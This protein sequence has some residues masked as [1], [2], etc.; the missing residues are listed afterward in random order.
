MKPLVRI[1]NLVK[2][3]AKKGITNA[4]EEVRALDG[5]SFSIAAGATLAIVGESGS[6]K[7]TLAL[8]LAGLE[9]PTSGSI[10]LEEADIVRLP[11]RKR[12]WMRRKIQLIFQDPVS[13]LNPRW[14]VREILA[15]PFLL[16]HDVPREEIAP[17]VRSLLAQ[18]GLSPDMEE[19]FPAELSGGQR[20]RLAIARALALAPKVL[21]LDEALSA[22]DCSVQAQITNLLLELQ[23]SL[24]MTYIFISHDLAM[25]AHMADEVAVMAHGRIVEQGLPEKILKQPQSEVTRELLAADPR[26][27]Y[28]WADLLEP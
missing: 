12:R 9:I 5:V 13:S 20:Q 28:S 26:M 4:H 6:G 19:R 22:L 3:Y 23:R 15:E 25:A 17:R 11:E 18:V 14:N 7:S 1:E 21:I 8:C 24:G 16:G 27:N 2:T 10:W